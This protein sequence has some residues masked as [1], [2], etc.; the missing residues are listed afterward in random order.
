MTTAREDCFWCG[1]YLD[2]DGRCEDC[3]SQLQKLIAD[4][5]S[6]S[7]AKRLDVQMNV[8]A[9]QASGENGTVF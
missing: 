4:G 1:E 5:H 3:G 9:P 7:Q 8:R 2:D 6:K